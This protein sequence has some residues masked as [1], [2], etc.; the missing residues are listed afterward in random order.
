MNPAQTPAI[1]LVED[2]P[3][4]G[5]YLTA[6]TEALPARVDAAA[7]IAQ[8]LQY[9]AAGAHDLWLIDANLPDG[10]G[11]ELLGRLRERAPATPALAHTAAH[12]R[13]AHAPLLAAG[14]A[15]V[16]V[17]PIDA[18]AW[19]RAIRRTLGRAV[20][21]STCREA[22]ADADGEPPL[23]DDAAAAR[24]LGGSAANVAALRGLFLAELPGQV[25]AIRGG[26]GDASRGQLHRLR[27]SCAF[28]GACRLE[29]AVRRLQEAR[30]DAA[31]PAF[32]RI[33][34]AT[35]AHKPD[36]PA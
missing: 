30:D 34:E 10:S 25:A 21:D 27:A 4:T 23:W 32:V 7:S 28:V 8:A 36:G 19:R 17:K 24:A 20:A 14:F 29:Q 1:L 16:L 18:E 6:L 2:D 9:A 22:V 33:A 13:G 12:E 5:A 26:D 11:V 15:E 31:L 35:L 3:T